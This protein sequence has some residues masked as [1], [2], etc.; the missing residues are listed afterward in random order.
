M[1]LPNQTL[2]KLEQTEQAGTDNRS[3]LGKTN[4]TKNWP[5]LI[6]TIP[7][8]GPDWA[9]P[10]LLDQSETRS[11]TLGQTEQTQDLGNTEH[12][13][14]ADPGTDQAGSGPVPDHRQTQGR[15]W[16]RPSWPKI[17]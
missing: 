4:Q 15:P 13:P 2:V 7:R 10:Y 16:A 5:F 11:T 14:K 17:N 1:D 12:T 9:Y 3:T 8:P 6:R